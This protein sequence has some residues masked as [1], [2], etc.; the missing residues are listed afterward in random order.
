MREVIILIK[1]AVGRELPEM[2][3]TYQV[4]PFAGIDSDCSSDQPVMSN[5]RLSTVKPGKKIAAGIKAAVEAS[6]LKDGMT[7]SFHHSFREGD[8]VIG[9]VLSVIKELGIKGLKFAPSAV[10]NI[11]NPS[12]VDYVKDGTIAS[13]EASGIRGELGD[14]VLGGSYGRTG[15]PAPPR[16][17]AKSH[18]GRGIVHR[19]G[20]YRRVGGR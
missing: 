3:G 19:R 2:I 20:I 11:K 15:N 1:N 16:S 6:G 7:I 4:R 8:Q 13:I 5:R 12:I 18:R 17:Q 14:A 9:R 10:V